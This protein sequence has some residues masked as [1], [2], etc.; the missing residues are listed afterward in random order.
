MISMQR[1]IY[2]L[3]F[4]V[5][6]LGGFLEGPTVKAVGISISTVASSTTRGQSV[7]LP[8]LMYHYVE[9][10]RDVHDKMRIALTTPPSVF[11]KQVATLAEAGYTFLTPRV[12]PEVLSGAVKLSEKS[13]ILSFDD[14]YED[15]FSNV[16]PV[17][18][19]YHAK[20]VAYIIS[21]FVG[22]PDYLTHRE[23]S[24]L[25]ASTVFEVGA[26]TMHHIALKKQPLNI[27]EAEI[28]GSK[29]ALEKELGMT[30]V[31]FAYPYGSYDAVAVSEVQKAGFTNAVSTHSGKIISFKNL[32]TLLRLRPGFRTGPALLKLVAAPTVGVSHHST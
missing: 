25:A 30:I 12:I 20:G 22:R 1:F 28:A 11:K 4:A 2:S 3:F 7:F 15:L 10:M 27:I 23:L 5:L 29:R 6:V 14:G 18:S 16:Y 31:S 32:F 26:H 19:S 17:L 13:V 9:P 8:I 21:G 24:T